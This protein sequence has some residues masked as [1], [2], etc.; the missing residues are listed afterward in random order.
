MRNFI[1]LFVAIQIVVGCGSPSVYRDESFVRESPFH[2]EFVAPATEVCESAQRALLSQAYRI[3]RLDGLNV[4]ARKDFQPDDEVN[5]TI[6]FDVTCK[7]TS[8]GTVVFVNAIETTHK[9][10]K[11]AGATSLS[12]PGAG[13]ISMPWSKSS[14]SLV[15]VAGT[16]ISDATFYRRFL[17]LVA[18]FLN[19]P[20]APIEGQSSRRTQM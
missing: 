7:A 18:S 11:T 12:L 15:K 20:L 4:R 17:D 8:S 13:S 19:R 2:R 14:D 16:T 3:E 1:V 5:V 6:D 10:K 9:L